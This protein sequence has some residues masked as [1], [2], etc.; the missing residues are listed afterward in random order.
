MLAEDI[1][2]PAKQRKGLLNGEDLL[3]AIAVE[4]IGKGGE[5]FAL[6]A[7]EMGEIN[8]VAAILRY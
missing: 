5:V 2:V 8:P 3:N 6:P 1:E 7:Q 4:T